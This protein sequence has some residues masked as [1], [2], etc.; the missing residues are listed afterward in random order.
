MAAAPVDALLLELGQ[1]AIEVA[2]ADRDVTVAGAVLVAAAVVV[3]GQLQDVGLPV[4]AHEV[5]GRLEL[6]VSDDRRSLPG[7][8]PSAS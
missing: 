1:G 8:K 6:A 5:V 4:Q 2:D 3:E 7:V